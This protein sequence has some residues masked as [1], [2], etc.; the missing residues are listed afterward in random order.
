MQERTTHE[1]TTGSKQSDGSL[2]VDLILLYH[3][4]LNSRDIASPNKTG[5]QPHYFPILLFCLSTW[6][7]F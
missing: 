7:H 5:P 3:I 4:T 1:S 6:L 2:D